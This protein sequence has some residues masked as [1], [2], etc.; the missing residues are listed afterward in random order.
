M[1][2]YFGVAMDKLNEYLQSLESLKLQTKIVGHVIEKAKANEDGSISFYLVTNDLD[3]A[4]EVLLPKGA[5]LKNYK[6]NPVWLWAHNYWEPPIGKVNPKTIEVTDTF[7][8]VDVFFDEEN[9]PFAK[10]IANK[11]RS[12]FL[13]AASV[14]FMP[15]I[16]SK[17]PEQPKQTGRTYIKY[18]VYEGSSVPVPANPGALNLSVWHEFLETGIKTG[19][20]TENSVKAALAQAGWNDYEIKHAVPEIG[21][22]ISVLELEDKSVIPYKKFDKPLPEFKDIDWIEV[23]ENNEIEIDFEKVNLKKAVEIFEEDY[24]KELLRESIT[25]EVCGELEENEY[26]NQIVRQIKKVSGDPSQRLL[27][28]LDEL[29]QTAK[30]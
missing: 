14:G 10:M 26:I 25:I 5:V 20:L 6:K 21:H 28:K 16:T 24:L 23:K 12:G 8:K 30:E 19:H 11:H 2:F 9:D 15:I 18:E 27:D 4:S 17:E 29:K 3:R 13:N 7:L 22:S 1:V